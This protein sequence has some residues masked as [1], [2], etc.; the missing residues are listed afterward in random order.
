MELFGF[1]LFKRNHLD[2]VFFDRRKS[3]E[4]LL[5]KVK[6][7]LIFDVGANSGQTVL[8]MLNWFPSSQ[9]HAF[10][11]LVEPY[12]Q[13]Q[14]RSQD[15]ARVICN[16]L[17]LS[18]R[19]GADTYFMNKAYSLSSGLE[20]PD[21]LS[22]SAMR[23]THSKDH[24]ADRDNF[25][26]LDVVTS[27]I[28]TYCSGKGIQNIDL[29]KIDVQGAESKVLRGAQS[30]LRNNKIGVVLTEISLDGIYKN[31][32]SFH[33]VEELLQPHGFRLWDICHIYKD[34]K[35]ARTCWVDAV[36][37]HE[38]NLAIKSLYDSYQRI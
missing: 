3:L 27:T 22:L 36:Y 7:P 16:Q 10:E 20:E 25:Q 15:F 5:S 37:V 31:R 17:A 8:Q 33:A 35:I 28:D 2:R 9:I 11:P 14:K 6:D 32:P 38:S 19:E 26:R 29:L 24:L 12:H 23:N 1:K 30:L 13:L 18:D 21:S 4:L 34:L